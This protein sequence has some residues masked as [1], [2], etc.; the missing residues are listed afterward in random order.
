[1]MTM[2]N[3]RGSRSAKIAKHL[4]LV[5]NEQIK[6]PKDAT[7]WR[8]PGISGRLTLSFIS[9]LLFGGVIR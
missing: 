9:I 1:M 2:L 3:E 5:L 7:I 6:A 4:N 8:F